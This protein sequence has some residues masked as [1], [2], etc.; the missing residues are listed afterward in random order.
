MAF[1]FAAT[2]HFGWTVE[3]AAEMVARGAV[4]SISNDAYNDF[5]NHYVSR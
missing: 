4:Y 2:P 3:A 1:V 5:H